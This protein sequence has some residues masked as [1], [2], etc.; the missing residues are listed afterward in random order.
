M[1]IKTSVILYS[2]FDV[3]GV[4]AD[5]GWQDKPL[6]LLLLGIET[7]IS[8]EGVCDECQL[9]LLLQ[10]CV[11][12][13][14]SVTAAKHTVSGGT[15]N[16]TYLNFSAAGSFGQGSHRRVAAGGPLIQLLPPE[17]ASLW[18]ISTFCSQQSLYFFKKSFICLHKSLHQWHTHDIQQHSQ[19]QA[20]G[21]IITRRKQH[22]MEM[23]KV[24]R[25]LYCKVV[26]F[27]S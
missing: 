20:T 22:W 17:L 11:W 10:V 14:V 9:F 6:S 1:F 25:I 3:Q 18:N 21:C 27:S 23:R 13:C 24:T 15:F 12:V 26:Y 7:E 16:V 2:S 19:H 5:P 8:L 4:S